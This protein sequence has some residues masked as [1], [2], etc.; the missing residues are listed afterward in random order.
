MRSF[1]NKTESRVSTTVTALLNGVL[2]NDPLTTKHTSI[3]CGSEE[4]G[5]DE[6]ELTLDNTPLAIITR[7][8]TK[9]DAYT[10][11]H[12]LHRV[13]LST[14]TIVSGNVTTHLSNPDVVKQLWVTKLLG[15]LFCSQVGNIMETFLF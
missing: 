1:W 12:E 15:R 13:A 2:N 9:L 6:G 14:I 11:I 3:M 8:E 4:A 7:A 5:D 10:V